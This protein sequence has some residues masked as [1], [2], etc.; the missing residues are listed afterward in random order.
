MMGI[1]NRYLFLLLLLAGC[2]T[3]V[4]KGDD[5]L[6]VQK[7]RNSPP[8][9]DYLDGNLLIDS[10][11]NYYYFQYTRMR[12]SDGEEDNRPL[13]LDLRPAELVRLPEE[14]VLEVLQLNRLRVD[15]M[16]RFGK[17]QKD[18][19]AI[20]LEKDSMRR[21]FFRKLKSFL[22]EGGFFWGTRLLTQ[23]EAA[24]LQSKRNGGLYDPAFVEWD[25]TKTRFM[26]DTMKFTRPKIED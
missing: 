20:G 1:L 3:P 16:D 17:N 14:G 2:A 22:Q 18:R 23:E 13:F 12:F 25:S 24:M 6:A 26:L 9:F 19:L 4:K 5:W 21:P 8:Y 7:G 11:G 10:L 15:T